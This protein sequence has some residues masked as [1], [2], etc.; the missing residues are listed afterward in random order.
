[1]DVNYK[2]PRN[3]RWC[4]LVSTVRHFNGERKSVL[5][6]N[7]YNW[8]WGLSKLDV[9]KLWETSHSWLAGYIYKS[10]EFH[11]QLPNRAEMWH[12]NPRQPR[13]ETALAEQELLLPAKDEM[14]RELS[15]CS[16]CNRPGNFTHLLSCALQEN[17][18][19]LAWGKWPAHWRLCRNQW[20][21]RWWLQTQTPER[22]K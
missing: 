14:E 13:T 18:N 16:S 7:F 6:G 2:L 21:T 19:C 22:A 12:T 4:L 10:L 5:R 1:M 3:K 20:Q 11:L 17:R 15:H 9:V 8:I